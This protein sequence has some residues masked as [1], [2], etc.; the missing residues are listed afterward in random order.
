MK[1]FRAIVI[2]MGIWGLGVAAFISSFSIPVMEDVEQQAN[3]VLFFTVLPLVWFGAKHYYRKE[4]KTRGIW[5]GL[6]FFLVAA[7]LD[8]LVTVPFLVIP[9]G[10][11]HYEFFTD[12]SFWL[13]GLEFVSVAVAYR[14]LMIGKQSEFI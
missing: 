5:V 4:Q 13:I 9:N 14:Y 7:I 8:A 11:S 12:T 6:I 2:G 1:T 3:L 10:G